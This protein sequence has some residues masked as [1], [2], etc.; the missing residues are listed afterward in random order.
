M[1]FN[2]LNTVRKKILA[3]NI[4]LLIILIMGLLY[5]M[6]DISHNQVI[7]NKQ[8]TAVE[9]MTIISKIKNL[10]VLVRTS[11]LELTVLQQDASKQQ[12]ENSHIQ[13]QKLIKNSNISTI[14]KNA[15]EYQS[16]Y[17]KIGLATIAFVDGRRLQ[18]TVQLN[19]SLKLANSLSESFNTGFETANAKVNQLSQKVSESNERIGYV[20]NI[21]IIATLILGLGLSYFIAKKISRSIVSLQKTLKKIE[22]TN[23]LTIVASNISDDETGHLADSFNQL[24]SQLGEIIKDVRQHSEQVASASTEL[25]AITEQSSKGAQEQSD[26]II[27][28]ATAMTEM[29]A[30]VREVAR[31]AEAAAISA[32]TGDQE[33][34]KGKKIVEQSIIAIQ[35]MA[36]DVQNSALVIE[37]LKV[38]SDRIGQVVDVINS[39]AEQTNLLALNAAIEAARAGEQG[40]GFAVV[41]DEV[42]ALAQRTQEATRE[43]EASVSSLQSGTEKAVTVIGASQSTVDETIIQSR[44]AGD[45]LLSITE[46]VSTIQAMNTQ[47]ATAAEQQHVTSEDINR[48]ITNIQTVSTQ[49]ATSTTEIASASSELSQLGNK[50]NH[51]VAQFKVKPA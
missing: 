43:I 2:F 44:V 41:A 36:A 45:A 15:A 25:S 1:N 47:I 30:T 22:D 19:E 5:V 46:A 40:R 37:S 9:Q 51:L 31:N 7:V 17:E 49:T 32:D 39:I 38:E 48:N 14:G 26:A 18:G 34:K 4:A 11:A 13:L 23:D 50:L 12:L 33:A 3:G 10:F 16:F 8:K 24:I 27:Q 6:N 21:I 28:V 42:R 20:I 29:E 35:D